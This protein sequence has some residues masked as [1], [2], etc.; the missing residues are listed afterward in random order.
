MNISLI[1]PQIFLTCWAAL[2]IAIDFLKK[3][4]SRR[5]LGYLSILGLAITAVLAVFADNGQGFFGTYL[6]DDYGRLFNEIFL[7]TAMLTIIAS[8]DF[9]EIKIKHKGEFYGLILLATVGMMFLS[10]AGELITLY[11]SLE[12][13]TIPLYVLAA[14]LKKDL[15]STEAGLKY[16]IIGGASSGILLFGLSLLYGLTG[17][18]MLADINSWDLTNE[19]FSLGLGLAIVLF[20]AGFGFKLAAAPFHM[21]APD[22]YEGAPT[23]VTAFLSVASK[24][25]GLV[26]FVRIFFSPL[27]IVR[28]DWVL[29]LEI[30]AVLAMVIGNFVA[31]QQSNIKRMLAYSSIAQVGYVLVALAAGNGY[32]IIGMMIFLMAY[33]FANIGAFMVAIG[34]SNMTGSDQIDDYAGMIRRNPLASVMMT[35]FMLSLVGIPPTAGF[36]GKYWLFAAAVKGHIY[37]LVVV[38]VLM[39]VVSLF[40]YMNVVRMM[41]FRRHENESRILF[42]PTLGLGITVSGAMVILICV[43]PST[44]YEWA[45][46]AARVFF[47][48][49]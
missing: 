13:A 8:I 1:I 22:V 47:P 16:L 46:Q 31:L 21:W 32:S 4:G 42:G 18:T 29:L 6:S 44:F 37:W 30:V 24:A 20:I 49:L 27:I 11:V 26:A 43:L 34:F 15:K 2:I 14:F 17:T 40:Y 19:T 9:V 5:G 48:Q 39:S 38:A 7:L 45:I 12:L 3:D 41:F 33:V 25:A 35:I 23:P 10:G 28:T 36:L